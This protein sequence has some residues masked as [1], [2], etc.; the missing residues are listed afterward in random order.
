MDLVGSVGL[1]IESLVPDSKRDRKAHN[2]KHPSGR[3]AFS[4]IKTR[5]R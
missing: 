4:E 2:S 5:V 3:S 1:V